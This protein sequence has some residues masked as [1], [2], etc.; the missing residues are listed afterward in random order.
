MELRVIG[1]EEPAEQ[2]SAAEAGLGAGEL[3][4]IPMEPVAEELFEM[5]EEA[6]VEEVPADPLT[7]MIEGWL[8]YHEATGPLPHQQ[9]FGTY[10]RTKAGD[11]AQ[12]VRE[13]LA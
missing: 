2:E 12:Q 4:T 7:S 11:L 5:P 9:H 6:V 10:L 8:C 13:F 3:G 1:Q